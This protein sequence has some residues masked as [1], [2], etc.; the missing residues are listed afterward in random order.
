MM[1]KLLLF[2]AVCAAFVACNQ[3]EESYSPLVPGKHCTLTAIID[4]NQ[5]A[6]TKITPDL[7]NIGT[8]LAFKWEEG[9]IVTISNVSGSEEFT[10]V[11]SSISSDGKTADF[12]GI[13]LEDMSSYKVTY[14]D[15]T[16]TTIS[17]QEGTFKPI[18][19]GTGK[20]ASF[21]I[22]SYYPVLDLTLT[23]A[24]N[25]TSVKYY[26]NN[27]LKTTLDCGSGIALTSTAKKVYFPVMSEAADKTAKLEFYNGENLILVQ[28]LPCAVAKNDYIQFPTLSVAPAKYICFESTDGKEF[29][30]GL[31]SGRSLY[32]TL[33][34]TTTPTDPTT[35]ATFDVA[36]GTL[37]IPGDTKLYVRAGNTPNAHL[38]DKIMGWIWN[39]YTSLFVSTGSIKVSGN[40]MALLNQ[41]PA[42]ELTSDNLYAFYTIFMGTSIVDASELILPTNVVESCFGWLFCGCTALQL[43]PILPATTMATTCYKYMFQG[44]SS[45]KSVP[46][47]PAKEIA[48][49]CYSDMFSC[50]SALESVPTDLLPA[51]TLYNQCY[52]NMFIYCSKLKN[53]PDLP[54]TTLAGS[55]YMAMFDYCTNLEAA[56]V[57]AAE[58][59]MPSCYGCMFAACP[60]INSV[61]MLGSLENDDDS[62]LDWLAG[63][64]AT[65]TVYV[66]DAATKAILETLQYTTAAGTSP[67]IPTNWTVEVKSN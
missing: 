38:A 62:L 53:A 26:V 36:A 11:A 30:V 57:L 19:S 25:V 59:L 58:T 27:E 17:Y 42:T 60:N 56:P 49:G 23:G 7:A 20:D 9:D 46:A 64:A 14:G 34:Y 12:E 4:Q 41:E 50:C 44:C 37:T 45:L 35:W 63:A 24:I 16:V 13:A 65:G 39:F 67:A 10:V 22:D 43:A 48:A 40:I 1:K 32:P 51:K 33:Q 61:T 31:Q 5:A 3:I 28:Y 8:S 2:A 55:C 29:T 66:K 47:L 15:S 52:Y 6:Q 18:A 54:A 21:T